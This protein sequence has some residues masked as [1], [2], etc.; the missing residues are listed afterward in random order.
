M[1]KRKVSALAAYGSGLKPSRDSRD[2]ALMHV[3]DTLPQEIISPIVSFIPR[4]DDDEGVRCI[5]LNDGGGWSAPAISQLPLYATLS[6]TWNKV[7]EARTF[8]TLAVQY[9]E[10]ASFRSI[11]TGSRREYVTH[12]TYRIL[13]PSHGDKPYGKAE[14][15]IAFLSIMKDWEKN[16]V[17]TAVALSI[18]SGA[19]LCNT[20]NA[21][22]SHAVLAAESHLSPSRSI[23][24]F[25][26]TV[27]G[28]M[29]LNIQSLSVNCTVRH[30]ITPTTGPI[31]ARAF[32]S[33]RELHLVFGGN[34]W[35][36]RAPRNIPVASH[37]RYRQD[38]LDALR[39]VR[40]QPR[41][42]ASIIDE[43]VHDCRSYVG[44]ILPPADSYDSFSATMR[45]FS[46][47][48]KSLTLTARLDATMFWPSEHEVHATI[49]TWPFLQTLR[50]EVDVKRQTASYTSV[51]VNSPST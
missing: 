23:V 49:P 38:L 25:L 34:Y 41:S 43:A 13:L 1:W 29:L 5:S 47:T 15:I 42:V 7:I 44:N 32:P 37:I 10:L 48:L 16:G 21:K 51:F 40:L 28:F 30:L 2:R 4:Y 46:H 9:T 19:I 27:P 35:Q 45:K 24:Q 3:M 12:L 18:P 6:R 33:L 8:K 11:V 14:H 39:D 26:I 36:P 22:K 20:D 50:V 31:F 17:R